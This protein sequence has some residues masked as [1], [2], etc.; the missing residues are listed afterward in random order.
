MAKYDVIMSD[1]RPPRNQH[2]CIYYDPDQCFGMICH[3]CIHY[4]S[5]NS[6]KNK[7]GRNVRK[8]RQ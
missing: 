1:P 5:E 7:P 8:K 4:E 2:S 3:K 6:A